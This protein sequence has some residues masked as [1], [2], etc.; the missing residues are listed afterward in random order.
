MKQYI[1]PE[2][3]EAAAMALTLQSLSKF[4]ILEPYMTDGK[5]SYANLRRAWMNHCLEDEDVRQTKVY[6]NSKVVQGDHWAYATWEMFKADFITLTS[7]NT[8]NCQ[9]PA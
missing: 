7:V 5:M 1:K 8:E 4:G 6:M 9:E 3:R 2:E